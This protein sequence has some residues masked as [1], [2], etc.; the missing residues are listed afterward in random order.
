MNW[1]KKS[2]TEKSLWVDDNR[3]PKDEDTQRV[4]GT[5]GD[6]VWAKT[7]KEAIEY[8]KTNQFTYV[9]LDN[10]LGDIMINGEG[11]GVAKWI[12]EHAYTGELNRLQWR[13]HTQNWAKSPQIE[14]ALINADKFWDANEKLESSN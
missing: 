11:Y 1:Y 7:E 12:E 3:D 13:I 5:I 9:S 6:E 14:M 10:D 2:Q 4:F 8:L